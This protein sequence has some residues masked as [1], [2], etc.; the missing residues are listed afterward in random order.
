MVAGY[1]LGLLLASAVALYA[2]TLWLGTYDG[3]QDCIWQVVLVMTFF[4]SMH[5]AL[6]IQNPFLGKAAFLIFVTILPFVTKDRVPFPIQTLGCPSPMNYFMMVH[7]SICAALLTRSPSISIHLVK[8]PYPGWSPS[9]DGRVSL[10]FEAV[11]LLCAVLSVVYLGCCWKW[12]KDGTGQHD[13]LSDA[14]YHM[15]WS[16]LRP[17]YVLCFALYLFAMPPKCC[18]VSPMLAGF[19]LVFFAAF[20]PITDTLMSH[21]F[22]TVCVDGQIQTLPYLYSDNTIGQAWHSLEG[23]SFNIS[24]ALFITNGVHHG[25]WIDSNGSRKVEHIILGCMLLAFSVNAITRFVG[26]F[27]GLKMGFV[28]FVITRYYLAYFTIIFAE[29]YAIST[30]RCHRLLVDVKSGGCRQVKVSPEEKP[31]WNL[32]F[33]LAESDRIPRLLGTR[34]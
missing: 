23:M 32:D 30:L 15:T 9:K 6:S 25:S 34:L 4:G 5:L 26:H 2:V 3:V 22:N 33:Y 20:C 11:P 8:E 31:D 17:S 13:V 7:S 16:L 24:M 27:L 28:W 19:G 12:S 14:V 29:I 18:G 10:Y 1:V 21:R